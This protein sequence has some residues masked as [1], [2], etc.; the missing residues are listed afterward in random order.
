MENKQHKL[1]VEAEAIEQA[2]NF[3]RNFEI[4][5][6]TTELDYLLYRS[7]DHVTFGRILAMY[8]LALSAEGFIKQLR[9]GLRNMRQEVQ[10]D[11]D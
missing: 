3:V 10:N 7:R 8:R 4:E 5:K 11:D 1:Q 6:I 2:E 9:V